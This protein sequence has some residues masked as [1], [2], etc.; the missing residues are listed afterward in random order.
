MKWFGSSKISLMLIGL[1]GLT[2]VSLAVEDTWTAKSPMPTARYGL[3]SSVVDGKLYAI[4]GTS[5]PACLSAVEAY[6]PVTDTWTKKADMPMANAGAASSVVN[7]KIYVIGGKP[8][9][10][11]APYSSV[12]EYDAATD[13]WTAKTDMPT[14]RGWV[15][16]SVVNGKIYAIGGA[17]DYKGTPLST[18]EE[19]DPA[20]D[21]WTRK[22]DMP[23]ARVCVSTS[24]V[25]GKIYAIGGNLS[26]PWLRGLSTVEEYNPATNTWTK[27]ADMP[28]GR[29][30]LSTSVVNGKIYAIG[31]VM[32]NNYLSRVEQYDPATD[33]W[34]SKADM[35]TARQG[36]STSVANGKI[37]A[38]GGWVGTAISTVEEYTPP[39]PV[40][41]VILHVDADAAG[42]NNG[43]SWAAAFKNLQDALAVAR[44]EDEIRVAQG[45]YKPAEYIPPP[46]P[47]GGD[48][49]DTGTTI[50]D[51]DQ[52]ATFQLINGVAIYGGYAGFGEPDPNARD[53]QLYETIL[54]GD[55]NGNDIDVNDTH[56]LL[57]DPCRADNS[58][59]VVTGSGTDPT[60]ALDGFTITRG[61]ANGSNPDDNGGGMF[62]D[63]G[64]P[65]LTNCK[66]I[67]NSAHNGGGVYSNGGSPTMTNCMFRG[68]HAIEGGGMHTRNSNPALTNCTFTVNRAD[69]NVGGIYNEEGS[70]L[71][72][73]NCI[74]WGDEPNEIVDGALSSTTVTYSNV[75]G[76][77]PGETNIDA[78]PC[79]ADADNGD[80]HLKSQAGRWDPNSQ[81]WVQDAV[82]SPCIDVGDS[83]SD[84]TAELWPHGERINMGAYGGT[85]EASM[86][87]SDAGN[88]ADLNLDGRADYRD[89]KLLTNKWLY[90]GV[91]AEDIS[92]DGVVNFTDFAIFAPILELPASNPN[93]PDGA[94]GID[95]DTDLSWTAGRGATSHDV[96]FGTN[97]TPGVGEFKVNQTSTTF[98]PGTM[99]YSTTYYWRID[100]VNKR[101][102]TTGQIWSFS[103]MMHPPP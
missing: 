84:W 14:A 7:G 37:Y 20:T 13:T 39:S 66:L 74:L 67:G 9:L 29:T 19:Y 79:F 23:T 68:N 45:I 69:A 12:I 5:G 77:W 35:P 46:P 78:D 6:D 8:S 26:D 64:S 61:N 41:P 24:A 49:T 50:T 88:M 28:T 1:L 44:R 73:T 38:I 15:S 62:N 86:S 10:Y 95:I 99:A 56:E 16:S 81:T 55:I 17:R 75:Q 52:T 48:S 103:T 101:G 100:E 31:G 85:P 91:L 43:T 72:L 33:T 93:P 63:N 36:L 70:S 90:K 76:G 11:G 96:Y 71:T 40:I 57:N 2:S 30:Y 65:T 89:M 97:P 58:Y 83:G 25:N 27:K 4:G 51:G 32:D 59:H 87:L 60:A 82:T 21:T 102:K 34:T 3:S 47:P 54:S 98:D 42:A 18:V 92:R 80:C 94:T 53:I 22:A